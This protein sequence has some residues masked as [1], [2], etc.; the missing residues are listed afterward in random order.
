M[1]PEAEPHVPREEKSIGPA[2][3]VGVVPA[4]QAPPAPVTEPETE[5]EGPVF[6]PLKTDTERLT[7]EIPLYVGDQIRRRA[8]ENRYSTR[9]IILSALKA[10]GFDVKTED[11]TLLMRP[12]MGSDTGFGRAS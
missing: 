7:V 9:Y 8:F 4:P 11:L 12:G 1:A 5:A 10:N 2:E 6:E 3:A